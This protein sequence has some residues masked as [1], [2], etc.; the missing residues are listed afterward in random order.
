MKNE[1]DFVI[2]NLVSLSR[3]DCTACC[4]A[5]VVKFDHY[6]FVIVLMVLGV[7]ILMAGA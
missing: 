1:V 6:A 3:I 7:C 2:I 5:L 4:L